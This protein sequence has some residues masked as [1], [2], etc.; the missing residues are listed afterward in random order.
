M[1]NNRLKKLQFVVGLVLLTLVIVAFVLFVPSK[2]E[3][4]GLRYRRIVGGPL[5][6]SYSV[7]R[8]LSPDRVEE[9]IKSAKWSLVFYSMARTRPY[10]VLE[11]DG[12]KLYILKNGHASLVYADRGIL[13]S[14]HSDLNH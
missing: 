1:D 13:N 12:F 3:L 6:D 9:L 7:K 4:G 5:S 11:G 2:H 14:F 8:G 10:E